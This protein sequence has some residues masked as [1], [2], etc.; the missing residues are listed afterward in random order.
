[1]EEG[2]DVWAVAN[3][4]V[5]VTPLQLDTI[6]YALIVAQLVQVEQLKSWGLWS[7]Y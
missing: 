3:N 2:T 5:S 1:L 6:D 7:S 4:Y